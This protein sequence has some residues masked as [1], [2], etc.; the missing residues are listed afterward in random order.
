MYC[1]CILFISLENFFVACV[2]GDP[3]IVTLDGHKYTFNGK[4]EFTLIQTDSE[5][6]SLQGRMEQVMDNEGL[7]A[8]GTAFT[9]IVAKQLQSNTSVQFEVIPETSL[10]QVLINGEKV[11]FDDIAVQQYDEVILQN[12]GNE[13]VQALF[14]NGANVEIT[15]SNGI[16]SV[17]LVALPESMKRTT[18]GLMGSYNGILS[19]DLTPREGGPP[20]PLDDSLENIHNKFGITCK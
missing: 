16:I 2:Y 10:L 14:S 9:A 11:T 13:T 18:R 7:P 17:M 19:D 6:F 1:S 20:L 12:K 5:V 8:P 4:G 15:V 3:H